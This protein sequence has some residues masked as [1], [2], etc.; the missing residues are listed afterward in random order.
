MCKSVIPSV[1]RVQHPVPLGPI[2]MM[3]GDSGFK[4]FELHLRH[5]KP[6]YF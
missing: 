1:L 2:F 3:V 5:E 4:L 6:L